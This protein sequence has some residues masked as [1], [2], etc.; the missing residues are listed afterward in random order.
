MEREINLLQFL[1]E[2][3]DERIADRMSQTENNAA[4]VELKNNIIC[5]MEDACARE[6]VK[7]AILKYEEMKNQQIN[8]M[9]KH[10]YFEGTRDVILL[11]RIIVKLI[12]SGGI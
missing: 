3:L 4:Y 9:A 10:M 12:V 11:S 5:H 6:S 7:V 8:I 1:N 2:V